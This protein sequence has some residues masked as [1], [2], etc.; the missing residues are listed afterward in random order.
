M[1]TLVK[2]HDFRTRPA[3]I[4]LGVDVAGSQDLGE[5]RNAAVA[6]FRRQQ[7][8]STHLQSGLAVSL[9]SRRPSPYRGP[10]WLQ[11]LQIVSMAAPGQ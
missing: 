1:L 8:C 4:E 9:C 11:G 3:E 6:G 5:L 10:R 2:L 7:A